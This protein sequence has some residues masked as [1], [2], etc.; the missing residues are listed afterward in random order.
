[1]FEHPLPLTIKP[2]KLAR[3]EGKLIGFMPLKQ[4]TQL[5]SDCVSDEGRVEAELELRMERARPELHGKARALVK[6]TC[7]RC[8]EPVD[9]Q[10][11][12][13]V[14]LGFVQNEE[15]IN[16]MPE[17]LEPFL[18][19]E[20]EVPLADLLEQELIL[21]LPIVAFHKSCEPYPYEGKEAAEAATA[22]EKPNPFAVLEQLKGKLNKSDK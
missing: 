14:A 20:E 3:Q 9:V 8:L 15:Q 7:Q 1:M 22:E 16:E 4:L 11:D 6:L 12:V 5:A 18:L 21:A 19:E 10:V 17:S 2:V 13:E